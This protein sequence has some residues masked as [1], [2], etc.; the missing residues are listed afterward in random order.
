VP[1]LNGRQVAKLSEGLRDSF[2]GS[3]ELDLF[4]TVMLD[5]RLDD[6]SSSTAN[7]KVR[8]FQLI[9][10]ADSEGWVRQLISAA[11]DARPSNVVLREIAA[12]VG[13]ESRPHDL[14]AAGLERII[15]ESVPFVDVSAWRA[16]LSELE[17]QVCRVEVPAGSRSTVGTG[18]LVGPDVC[19]TNFHVVKVL[20]DQM[21]DPHQ[22]RLRFDYKRTDDGTVVNAGSVFGLADDWL[23]GGRPPSATDSLADPGGQLPAQDELDFALLRVRDSPGEQSAGHAHGL[24]ESPRRGWIRRFSGDGVAAGN[25]LFILQ[26]PEDAPLKLAFGQSGGLN[27]NATRLRH[28]VNTRPGSSGSPC[29]NARLELVALH[30]AGDPNFSPTHKPAYNAAVPIAAIHDCLAGGGVADMLFPA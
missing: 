16:Q 19:L 25:P 9:R 1:T 18:F 20:A 22:V 3:D 6:V 2:A 29:L 23:I 28:Q 30:H 26:H 12:E 15:L 10:A 4:L 7:N 8:V 21:A 14:D 13:L 17:A 24:P 27:A 5:K 11:C